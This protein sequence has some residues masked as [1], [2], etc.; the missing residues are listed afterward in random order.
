MSLKD[1]YDVA[2]IGGG[3]AGSMAAIYLSNFGLDVCIIEKK[4]FP[5][6][7]LCGEFL[8]EE[9]SA[10]LKELK[11]FDKFLALN[12]VLISRFKS[13]NESGIE[14]HSNLSFPAYALKRSIFDSFM[15]NAAISFGVKVYQPAE[16]DFIRREDDKFLV[17]IIKQN[18]KEDILVGAENVIAAYGKQNSSDKKLK[19]DF[20]TSSSGMNGIKF[21]IP[22]RCIK[23]YSAD[24]I[25]IYTA[26]DIYCGINTISENETTLCALEKRTNVETS[27]RKRILKLLELNKNFG[28]LF[29]PDFKNMLNDLPVY[30]TGNIYFGRRKI[31]ENH[32]FMI[33][34]A[35]GVIAPLAGDG[36]GMAFQ[37]AKL[38]SSLLSDYNSRIYSRDQLE[39]T[40][41][42][43]WNKL[44]LRRIRFALFVQNL[45]LKSVTNNISYSLSN[46]FPTILPVLIKATRSA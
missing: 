24:E 11:L 14:I 21:H 42:M 44:F 33:G 13:V 36:I 38:I 6:D 19:R 45:V 35:A 10:I 8:S 18:N 34:D 4:K 43:E 23:N 26:E 37:S 27:P 29:E 41:V 40:Y 28:E 2:I 30:G 15:L 22:N 46:I 9:V 3:P 16:A 31:V 25:S 32:I 20:T 7:V 17:G 5:R 1:H 39:K 12:P